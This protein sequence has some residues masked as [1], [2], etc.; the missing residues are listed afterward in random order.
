MTK[1]DWS[2]VPSIVKFIATDKDGFKSYFELKP[3]IFMEG[4][5][6]DSDDGF[7]SQY[8]KSEFKGD[9]QDSLEERPLKS[10]LPETV[11][12]SLGEVA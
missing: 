5:I 11:V 2:N 4:W 12:K 10:D 1:Y 9:W 7:F 6:D 8:E 3:E